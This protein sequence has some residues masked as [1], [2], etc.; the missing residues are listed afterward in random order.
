MSSV[1]AV[2]F[3]T[4]GIDTHGGSTYKVGCRHSGM[5]TLLSKLNILKS[6]YKTYTV[7]ISGTYTVTSQANG[8]Q[9]TYHKFLK[10]GDVVSVPDSNTFRTTISRT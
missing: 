10:A 6:S 5:R 8:W 2:Y 3:D 7:P 9:G 1:S 4:A